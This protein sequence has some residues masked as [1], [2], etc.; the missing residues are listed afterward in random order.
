MKDLQRLRVE[1]T[2]QV[3]EA[4]RLAAAVCRGLGFDETFVG[5]LALVVT[6]MATNLLKHAAGGEILLRSVE[7]P[8]APG[9]EILS[10]DRGPGISNLGESL[11]DGH[12]TA[13][14]PGTG[15]GAIR[16]LSSLFDIYS[17]SGK[18]TAVLSRI[19]KTP[20]P[21]PPD[22]LP[23][24]T[25][26][27]GAVCL[28]V[29]GEEPCGDAWAV[30]Q[31]RDRALIMVADGLGHG[32]DAAEAAAE[33]VRV[34][35]KDATRGPGEIIHIMHSALK[36]TRG[37]AVAVAEVLRGQRIVRYAGVGNISGR[38]LSDDASRNMVSH[39]GTAG[40]EVRK[41]QEYTYPWPENGLLILHSD[42]LATH[43]SLDDYPGLHQKHPS[44]IA[45][46]L[47]RD[48]NRGRD[49]VTVVAAM[50]EKATP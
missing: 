50:E 23:P 1:D 38:I 39:N 22:P 48:H 37:A 7:W 44:L 49:D 35:R 18:G 31:V 20:P 30:H 28:P 36:S 32:Q 10:L 17:A 46:I 19:W 14:S 25:L 13:G 26:T 21:M 45:G 43:W 3:G 33:A 8:D 12:S 16:R 6:E 29:S 11:R 9:I 2:S 40:V 42:G 4:R 27:V 24:H 41:I 5:Q 47:F 15:L 34:F